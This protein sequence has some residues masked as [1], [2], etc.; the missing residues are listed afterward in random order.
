MFQPD[1][2]PLTRSPL[3]VTIVGGG[4]SAHV[5]IP[6]LSTRGHKVQLMTRK[7]S[8]WSKKVRLEHHSMKEEVLENFEGALSNISDLPEEV[9]SNADVIVLCMPVHQYRDAL[10]RLAPYISERKH[11]VFLGTVYG[12]GG[13]NWMVHEIEQKYDLHVVT[14]ACGLIPW[15]CRTIEY[16]HK[17]VIYGCK[18]VN[19]VAVTPAEKFARLNESFLMDICYRFFGK[20]KF[21]QACSFLSLT[22]SVDNQIIHPA[23]CFGLWRRYRG[24]WKNCDEVPLFYKDFDEVSAQTLAHL[25]MD[26]T[27]IRSAIRRRFSDR[28]FTFMLDYMSLERRTQGTNYDD[29]LGVIKTPTICIDGVHFLDTDSRFFKDDIP[30][31]LLIAKWMAE[32]LD[33]KTPFIDAVIDWAQTIRGEVFIRDGKIAIDECLKGKNRTGIPPSYGIYDIDALLD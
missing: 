26:F 22:L 13:F 6:L 11:E 15:I 3:T 7:P 32:R 27:N 24:R 18:H 17:G 14:F 28:P 16:G 23:R 25:D 9:I 31:G 20:G 8:M 2:S 33:L 10:H 30:Y 21:E 19:V 29:R 5:L 4:S 12:Q 1:K